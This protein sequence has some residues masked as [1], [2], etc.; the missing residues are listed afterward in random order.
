MDNQKF[1]QGGK[2]A[3]AAAYFNRIQNEKK[4]DSAETCQ[5]CLDYGD[6][7]HKDGYIV[8]ENENS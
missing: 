3:T 7:Y 4:G 6:F 8:K 1:V 2:S 5:E